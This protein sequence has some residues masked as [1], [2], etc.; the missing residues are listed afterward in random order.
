MLLIQGTAYLSWGLK[1]Y[2]ICNINLEKTRADLET[3]AFFLRF[4][5]L[6]LWF[7]GI[8]YEQRGCSAFSST[9]AE[10]KKGVGFAF[11]RF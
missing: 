5:G 8:S 1:F 11:R 3:F 6:P 4:E 2:E 10:T 9:Q 7:T